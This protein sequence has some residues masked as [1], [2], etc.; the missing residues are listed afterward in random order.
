MSNEKNYFNQDFSY[1]NTNILVESPIQLGSTAYLFRGDE[2]Q[3]SKGT[4]CDVIYSPD[5]SIP[6]KGE[7]V[8]EMCTHVGDMTVGVEHLT[9]CEPPK[10]PEERIWGSL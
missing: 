4:V 6:C 9:P 3:W 8:A 1:M 10:I 2:N 5:T 7:F